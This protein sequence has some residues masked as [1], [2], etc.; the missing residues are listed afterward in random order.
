MEHGVGGLQLFL[1]QS[2][3]AESLIIKD[4]DATSSIHEHFIKYVASNLWGNHQGQSSRVLYH[5]GVVIPCPGDRLFRTIKPPWTI[6]LC[7]HNHG[8]S[9]LQLHVP[10]IAASGEDM[11]S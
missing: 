9:L 8:G 3:P 6:R 4:I 1:S 5:L 2:H 7:D 11:I 10:S